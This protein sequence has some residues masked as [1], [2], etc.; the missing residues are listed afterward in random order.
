MVLFLLPVLLSERVLLY[1]WVLLFRIL[2]PIPSAVDASVLGRHL[3]V[4]YIFYACE[5]AEECRMVLCHILSFYRQVQEEVQY[6]R[7]SG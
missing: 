2:P 5:A 4:Y 1:R 7:T 6:F 3:I